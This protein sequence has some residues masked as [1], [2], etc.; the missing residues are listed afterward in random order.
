MGDLQLLPGVLAGGGGG[1]PPWGQWAKIIFDQTWA[2]QMVAITTGLEGQDVIGWAVVKGSHP[3]I[4]SNLE[5]KF[6]SYARE[7]KN[8]EELSVIDC[9]QKLHLG[10]AA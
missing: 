10:G 7:M 6:F 5:V 8:L 4:F 1:G 9:T 2:K 3:E